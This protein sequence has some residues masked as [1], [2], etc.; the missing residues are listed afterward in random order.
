VRRRAGPRARAAASPARKQ[1]PG[2]SRRDATGASPLRP[3]R[4]APPAT[5]PATPSSRGCTLCCASTRP[6]TCRGRPPSCRTPGSATCSTSSGTPCSASTSEGGAGREGSLRIASHW[7]M[8]GAP[9]SLARRAATFGPPQRRGLLCPPTPPPPPSRHP[10]P[11]P[12]QRA[13]ETFLQQVVSLLVASHYKNTPNDLLLLADAPAH[14][15]YVLLAPVDESQVRGGGAAGGWR[16]EGGFGSALAP[17]GA[18]GCRLGL[19]GSPPPPLVITQP[20]GRCRLPLPPPQN[21]L[22]DVLAVVQVALEGAIS[23]KAAQSSLARGELPQGDLIPWTV[24]QQ[25]QVGERGAQRRW[26]EA[27][28]T[29][30]DVRLARSYTLCGRNPGLHAPLRPPPPPPNRTPTSPGCRAPAS[31]ASRCTPSSRAR[32]TAAAASSCCGAT[33]RGSCQ[34]GGEVGRGGGGGK[35]GRGGGRQR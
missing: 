30:R 33:T 6:P 1:P 21:A 23:A 13:S 25:Y 27:A 29:V 3:S 12:P 7:G 34:V 9:C 24:G 26:W 20:P 19:A 16:G 18:D 15:L 22:P 10:H 5:R 35:R 4:P 11:P 32:A 8:L 14:Q 28:V 17:R 31:C 2:R